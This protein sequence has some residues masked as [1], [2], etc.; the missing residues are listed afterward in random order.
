MHPGLNRIKALDGLRTVAVLGVLWTHVWMFFDN[1]PWKIGPVDINRVISIGRNGVD[2][3]FVISGFCMYLMYHKKAANFS[4]EN[5]TSF[6]Y[7]RWRRI[8]PAFYVL[9][10]LETV[11]YLAR[12]CIFPTSNFLGHLFFVNIF[13]SKNVFSPHYWSLATEWHF[14][15]VL[16]LIFLFSKNST[17]VISNTFI[18]I[19]VSLVFRVF[20]FYIHRDNLVAK[21]TV[22][23]DAVWFRFAEF[24]FGIIA[25]VRYINGYKL[26]AILSGTLGFILAFMIAYAGRICMLTEFI[27]KFGEYAFMIRALGE[28]LMTLGFALILYNVITS[29]SIFS[30]VL[31]SRP[32]L[33]IGKISYSMYLWHWIIATLVSNLIIDKFGMNLWGFNAAVLLS[34]IVAIPVSWISYQLLEA[35]YFKKASTPM[36]KEPVI[37]VK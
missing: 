11:L 32:F 23:S 31:E 15:L 8:A 13:L 24:G 30:K 5:Y 1:I 36:A 28:P 4:L 16:P 12:T 17:R 9:I 29:E 37:A 22:N 3:F 20:L 14:Y 25:A 19:L 26:P 33:F 35:P 10:A 34:F 2:L 21:I 27:L 7:K 18:I 6:L